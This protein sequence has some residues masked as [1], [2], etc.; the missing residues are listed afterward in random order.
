[1]M[2]WW[3]TVIFTEQWALWFLLLIPA[4]GYFLFRTSGKKNPALKTGSLVFLKSAPVPSKIFWRPVLNV[5]RLLSLTLLILVFARP[6]S[7][8]GWKKSKGKGIDIMLSIDVSPSMQASDFQPNRLEA[9]KREAINF[10]KERYQDRVGVV[11]FS[12]EAFTVCPLTTDHFALKTLI[13]NIDLGALDMGTAIGMG[14]A[15]AVERLKESQAKSKVIV[16]LTDGE[17]NAGM[18]SPTDAGRLAK[19][20]GIKV[21]TIGLGAQNKR[22]LTPTVQNP[23]GSYVQQYQNSDIDE[24]SLIEIAQNTGGRYFRAS[25][26]RK[27]EQI[28]TEINKLEKTEFEKNQTEQREEEYFPFMIGV[29]LLLFIE[30]ILRYT[31]FN[32]LT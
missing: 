17:N 1:M 23:D 4:A 10:L 3:S 25:D 2:E 8:V 18:I 14:L 7:S 31:Y 22:V 11:I 27:L 20:Y 19:T 6:Q 12:G 16:L 28:Y 5:L 30:L 21:Y 24:K 15:K 32:T 9:A 29:L 13:E 26:G